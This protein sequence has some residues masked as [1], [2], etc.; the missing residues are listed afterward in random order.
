MTL[1]D[2]LEKCTPSNSCAGIAL[3]VIGIGYG[4]YTDT[5][6]GTVHGMICAGVGLLLLKVRT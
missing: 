2:L 1:R 3:V 4:V 5:P 6:E